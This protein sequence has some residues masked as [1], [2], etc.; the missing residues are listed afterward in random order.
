MKISLW[1]AK[2]AASEGL[3]PGA[4]VIARRRNMNTF[5]VAVIKIFR[6]H[7]RTYGVTLWRTR[8]AQIFAQPR[9]IFD[10]LPV[11]GHDVRQTGS[12]T[13]V[14]AGVSVDANA[15]AHDRPL[16]GAC[17]VA[18]QRGCQAFAVAFVLLGIFFVAMLPASQGSTGV[19]LA[20]A[21]QP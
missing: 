8:D 2:N 9:P 5:P 20:V 17:A 14:H 21:G 1:F 11:A 6:R 18:G 3:G 12:M 10:A 13:V 16:A 7:R 4:F 19:A 15:V